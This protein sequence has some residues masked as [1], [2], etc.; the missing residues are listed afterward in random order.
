MSRIGRSRASDEQEET[1][2]QVDD[3]RVKAPDKQR[4]IGGA[5]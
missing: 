2:R 1:D 3:Q 4:K 5:G